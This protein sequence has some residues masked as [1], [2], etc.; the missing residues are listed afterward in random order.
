MNTLTLFGQLMR[1]I[2]CKNTYSVHNNH[3]IQQEQAARGQLPLPAL[4][5][6][7]CIPL[8]EEAGMKTEIF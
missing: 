8:N 1:S 4:H 7:Q 6:I 5:Q 3:K 2:F